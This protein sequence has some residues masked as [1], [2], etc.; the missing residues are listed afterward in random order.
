MNNLLTQEEICAICLGLKR[1]KDFKVTN[2]YLRIA[3]YK[4]FKIFKAKSEPLDDFFIV[5][6]MTTLSKGN[7]VF[8]DKNDLVVEM[9]DAMEFQLDHLKLDTAVKLLTFPLTLGFS[10][11]KIEQHVF[12]RVRENEK[13]EP[14]DMVQLC[15]YMSRHTSEEIPIQEI[16]RC[17]DEKLDQLRDIDDL[18][19]MLS[20][21]NYLAHKSVYSDKFNRIIF[22]E[23]NSIPSAMFSNGRDVGALAKVIA[24][25]LLKRLNIPSDESRGTP[26]AR[27]DHKTT[28]ILTRIPAFLS[29]CWGLEVGPGGGS[30]SLPLLEPSKS[31][32]M[33]RV[34]HKD[35]P[36]QIFVPQMETGSLDKRSKQI[37]NC[38]RAL[39][40]F[41]G[42][43]Q[44][45]G[46]SRILPHF[47]EPD[48]VFGNIGGEGKSS[49]L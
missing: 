6:L 35:L 14:W 42:T 31:H 32:F 33:C 20:C 13:L 28:S 2:S 1:I 41:M 45:V 30:S 10:S 19:D 26:L 16:L 38:H 27:N 43:E 3:L 48:L 11:S 40:R 18:L 23:I 7:M 47:T 12:Q 9:L 21:Y 5:T 49:E 29:S 36:M 22:Q 8:N 37:V 17:L 15:S 24:S 34:Q 25:K 39:S 46:V 44:Y 4:Q